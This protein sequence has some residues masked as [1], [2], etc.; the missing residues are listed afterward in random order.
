MESQLEPL[1]NDPMVP[2]INGA[3]GSGDGDFA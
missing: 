2:A 1:A 3:S